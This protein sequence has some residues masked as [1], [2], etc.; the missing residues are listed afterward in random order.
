MYRKHRSSCYFPCRPISSFPILYLFRD[1]I[2][3]Q[4]LMFGA[5]SIWCGQTSFSGIIFCS[6]CYL[7]GWILTLLAINIS[8]CLCSALPYP[9]T[10]GYWGHLWWMLIRD[11]QKKIVSVWYMCICVCK[12]EGLKHSR[13]ILHE[14]NYPN[15]C[16]SLL[17][18]TLK[19]SVFF[20]FY[21]PP[22]LFSFPTFA[23][24]SFPLYPSTK[25]SICHYNI[26]L[27]RKCPVPHQFF[28]LN[29]YLFASLFLSLLS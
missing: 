20:F 9:F 24:L 7:S 29:F 14:E 16:S 23:F 8:L 28:W 25:I 10:Q 4:F 6:V 21:V 22:L 11:R 1:S 15:A 13:S 18:I 12:R 19:P 17:L 5:Y 27:Y 3:M 2:C 26:F